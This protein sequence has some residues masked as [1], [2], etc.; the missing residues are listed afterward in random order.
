MRK[1]HKEH[2]T[3]SDKVLVDYR[4]GASLRVLKDGYD[5]LLSVL[6]KFDVV[7]GGSVVA[8]GNVFLLVAA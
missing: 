3:R 1:P 4:A 2:V 5:D 8:E 6:L 7:D